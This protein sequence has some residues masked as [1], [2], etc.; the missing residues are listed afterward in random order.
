MSNFS[1]MADTGLMDIQGFTKVG[2]EPKSCDGEISAR[3][4]RG[5]TCEL[6]KDREIPARSGEPKSWMFKEVKVCGG[7]PCWEHCQLLTM[8]RHPLH[9]L[10]QPQGAVPV[11]RIRNSAHRCNLLSLVIVCA[12]MLLAP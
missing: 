4:S 1:D 2:G 8:P 3:A 9:S 10:N 12:V 5:S 7:A 11:Y 6:V